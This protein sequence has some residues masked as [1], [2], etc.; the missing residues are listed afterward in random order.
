[1]IEDKKPL[2][3]QVARRIIQEM[4]AVKAGEIVA[5][6]ADDGSEQVQTEAF[7]AA[8]LEVGAKPLVLTVRRARH[9]GQ[10]GMPDWPVEALEA[11]LKAADVWIET[12][13][14]F[15]LY[16]KLWET[17]MRDNERLRYN[18]LAGASTE[19]LNR[20]FCNY[21]IEKM[22]R[23]L[24]ILEAQAS[25]TKTVRITSAN[26]TDVFYDMDPQNQISFDSG[27][28][29]TKHFGTAPGYINFV[30]K[31]GSMT[32]RIRFDMIMHADLS[33]GGHVEFEMEAGK[34]VAFH[35]AESK[36]LEDY[37]TGL[38]EENMF[39][40]SHNMI[41]L[42]PGVRTLSWEIVEDERIWGGADFGFGYTSA[43]DMPPM[44]QPASSHFDGIVTQ[45][46]LWFDDT[47]I[48]RD[49]EFVLPDVR[50]EAA[51]LLAE[52]G[53]SR[54]LDRTRRSGEARIELALSRTVS[55]NVLQT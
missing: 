4:Y 50:D 29:S 42:C 28:F 20:V 43:I 17:V 45:I 21:D 19:S 47:L 1:M 2:A 14:A 22:A 25:K 3:L 12:N 8:C 32:G 37:V 35:G 15:M 44:G 10:A 11:A 41:G 33:Q 48:I 55:D 18:V 31:Y 34:I 6:T 7:F 40:I 52:Y 27:D 9:N 5:I 36:V 13:A 24:Q 53:R 38:G 39:K 54:G 26:G 30:P 51:A 16:S 49:G 46:S 23:L